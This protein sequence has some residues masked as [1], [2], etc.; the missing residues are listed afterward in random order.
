M[1][2]CGVAVAQ[3][4]SVLSTGRW[5]RL[6]VSEEGVYG[7]TP[8]DIPAL[9]GV[10]IDSI[11]VYG[12]DGAMLSTENHLTSTADLP[13]DA[14]AL[15]AFIKDERARELFQEGLRLWDLR[16]WGDPA[17]V[18]AIDAPNVK[19]TYNNYNISDLVYPI[20]ESEINSN[21][22]VK[23]TEGWSGTFPK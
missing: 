18:E 13:A 4:Q 17:Q 8:R 2:F 3:S 22:G 7:I 16:R 14:A 10:N 9:L 15:Y 12:R 11:A 5:W 1:A 19:F 21:W 23:Q 20:P 6:S